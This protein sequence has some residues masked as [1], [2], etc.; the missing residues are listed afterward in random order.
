[1]KRDKSAD[2]FFKQLNGLEKKLRNKVIKKGQRAGAKILAAE[3]KA[4]C[5]VESGDLKRSVKVRA[6][7]RRKG[8]TSIEVAIG[9]TSNKDVYYVGFVEFGTKRNGKVYP[10]RPFIRPAV[11]AK[12]AEIIEAV[13]NAIEVELNNGQWLKSKRL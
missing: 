7:K 13:G 12:R 4:R 3:I 5:P 2:R 9:T 8:K 1:M 11:D 6:G 10:A